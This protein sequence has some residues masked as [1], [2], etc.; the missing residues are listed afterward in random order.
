MNPLQ[1]MVPQ[2]V[3]GMMQQATPMV[4]QLAS[5]AVQ[6]VSQNPGMLM[7]IAQMIPG[8]AGATGGMNNG[9]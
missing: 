3:Q 6:Q 2:V 8:L 5:T 1:Q 9:R 4:N 7:Q